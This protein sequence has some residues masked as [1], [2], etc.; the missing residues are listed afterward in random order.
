MAAPDHPRQKFQRPAR[1]RIRRIERQLRQA[2]LHLPAQ[3]FAA[4]DGG[5]FLRFQSAADEQPH[6]AIVAHQAFD[7]PRR[8]RQGAGVEIAGAPIVALGVLQSGD[9][10]ETDEIAIVRGVAESPSSIA[11]HR[12]LQAADGLQRPDDDLTDAPHVWTNRAL[13]V[14]EAH[15]LD[16]GTFRALV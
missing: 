12:P 13:G 1:F 8:Q 14:E 16:C 2:P 11:Q 3:R 15:D 10:E 9:V 4:L 5:D 7:A 6:V